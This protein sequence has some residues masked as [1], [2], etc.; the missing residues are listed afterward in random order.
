MN[1]LSH[2]TSRET[3][4]DRP[5]SWR[6]LNKRATCDECLAVAHE[7]PNHTGNTLIAYGR[8]IRTVAGADL[9]LCWPHAEAWKARDR[10]E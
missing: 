2:L 10:G 8:T 1:Q 9:Y 6:K 5:V 3:A 4:G 7:T